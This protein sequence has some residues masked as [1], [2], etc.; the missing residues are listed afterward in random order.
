[1]DG[2]TI[3]SG[4]VSVGGDVVGRDI[5]KQEA[6][7]PVAD[8]CDPS[9]GQVGIPGARWA[10][11]GPHALPIHLRQIGICAGLRCGG[12]I[13]DYADNPGPDRQDAVPLVRHKLDR[14][15][16]P[17]TPRTV[18]LILSVYTFCSF[19]PCIL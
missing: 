17:M 9:P 2:V 6:P 1:M 12:H 19:L 10:G 8:H 3:T 15:L 11:L 14:R 4:D 16:E 18:T 13:G 7:A 5:I